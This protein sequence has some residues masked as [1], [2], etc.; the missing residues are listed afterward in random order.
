M[1]QHRSRSIL[2]YSS[3][4]QMGLA[5]LLIGVGLARPDQWHWLQWV[6]VVFSFHHGLIKT[7]LVLATLRGWQHGWQLAVLALGALALAGLPPTSG[8]LAKHLL[9][10]SALL[11]AE[12][13]QPWW[14][15]LLPL[16][17]LT[18][19]LMMI[20]FLR[21]CPRAR[22]GQARAWIGLLLASLAVWLAGFYLLPE[23]TRATL[24]GK[25]L[26]QALQPLLI[27]A[28]LVAGGRVL[29]LGLR[30]PEGDLLY[31]LSRIRPPGWRSLSARTHTG[32]MPAPLWP[33]LALLERRLRRTQVAGLLLLSL[34]AAL[35][36]LIA[37]P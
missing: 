7:G 18:T 23:L 25:S 15:I 12:P 16:T 5:T 21:R 1:G 28:L 8:W 31:I 17:S 29:G 24:S 20:Q 34:L 37:H 13:W 6:V 10:E 36:L 14:D 33:W 4:S 22:G 30:L 11:A 35:V 9:K 2:G 19:G 27:T 32:A 26:A 3:A